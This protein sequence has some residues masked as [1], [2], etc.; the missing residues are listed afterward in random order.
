[1][2]P[3]KKLSLDAFVREADIC[4]KFLTKFFTLGIYKISMRLSFLYLSFLY[5]LFSIPVFGIGIDSGGGKSTVGTLSNHG[6]IGSFV[7]T[8]TSNLGL[9]SNFSGLIEV[10]YVVP[11]R[12]PSDSDNDNMQDAWE[13]ENGLIVGVDDS[14][15][16]GDG[17]G[18]SNLMEYLAGT[19]PNYSGSV[20]KPIIAIEGN[21]STITMPS[22]LGRNYRL[23]VSTDL[24]DWEVWDYLAG[25]GNSVSFNFD[26]TSQVALNLFGVDVLPCC[27]YRIEI[28]LA[29]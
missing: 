1:V 14:E 26:R 13:N 24:T 28:S 9:N 4:R 23:W 2:A 16:D 27:F 20:Y 22:V 8:G 15:L 7:A 25:T 6:S 3:E 29:P 17:D 21:V 11:T 18:A 12:D 10:L 19:D 5:L